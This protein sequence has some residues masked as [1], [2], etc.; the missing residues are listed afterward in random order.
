M[1][2]YQIGPSLE[3][4]LWDVARL[5]YAQVPQMTG[6]LQRDQIKLATT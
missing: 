5:V 4:L 6:F 2:H 1:Q 3:A